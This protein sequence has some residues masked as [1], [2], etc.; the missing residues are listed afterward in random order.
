MD[1]LADFGDRQPAE[2][3]QAGRDVS[4][5]SPDGVQIGEGVLSIYGRLIAH[6]KQNGLTEKAAEEIMVAVKL[7]PTIASMTDRWADDGNSLSRSAMALLWERV[8]KP[9]TL[10]WIVENDPQAW[11][12]PLFEDAITLQ[13]IPT[14][15]DMARK[16]SQPADL[17]R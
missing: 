6:M 9:N 13:R 8:V 15:V 7:A 17:E 12:R 10:A 11:Y 4:P 1:I 16:I 5:V 14:G 3:G 2:E